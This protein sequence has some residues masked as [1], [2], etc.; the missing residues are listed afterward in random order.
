MLDMKEKT[1]CFTGHRIIPAAQQPA[2]E[3]R[4]EEEIEKLIQ[5]GVI[6]YGA[7][8]ALGFDTIAALTV[9]KLKSKYPQI[10][11]IL[12]L[13]CK[14]QSDRWNQEDKELYK[15]ILSKADKIRYTSE[16]YHKGCMH[17]RNRHLMDHSLYCICYLMKNTGGTA[18]TVVY[19]KEN[20]LNII[21]LCERINHNE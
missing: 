3:K 18:Y 13:P 1:C 11:L 14:N 4:L 12:V 6:F 21:N 9:L 15:Q 20:K 17:S 8:G 5:K 7:G 19:A 10:K 16:H 2:L